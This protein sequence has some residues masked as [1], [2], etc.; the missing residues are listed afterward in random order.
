M[1]L[2]NIMSWK[3]HIETITIKLNKAYYIIMRSK[4]YLNIDTLKMGHAVV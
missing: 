1:T 3:K 2:D 4:Q